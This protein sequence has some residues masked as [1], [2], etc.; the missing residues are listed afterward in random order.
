VI[1]IHPARRNAGS[2]PC[3]PA[4]DRWWLTALFIP[5][6]AVRHAGY[7]RVMPKVRR[8]KV[9]RW[10]LALVA[11]ALLA[12][13][14]RAAAAMP[15]PLA[16]L[17]A[18][19]TIRRST[20]QP[21]AK[22]VRY[23]ICST[24]VPS[25]DGTPLDV[26]VTL[27]V[28]SA[29]HPRP[30][31]V[32]LHGFL[33]DKTEYLSLSRGGVGADRGT[34]AYKTV[35]WN[36]VWFASRGYVVLNYTARGMGAS[37]GQ[38][39]LAS[40]YIEVRDT[41]YLT[42]LLIDDGASA[43]PLARIAARRI[44][45]IG[46]SYG[47]GQA[48]LLLTTKGAGAP[49]Y[50]SWLSP[51]GRLIEL[52]AIVPGFTW[53]DLLS[54]LV[55]NGHQLAEGVV[56]PATA[57]K[58]TGIG[59]Q[60]LI[61][62]FLATANTKLPSESIGWL[63]RFNAGEP[64][65]APSDPVIP[66]AE[67]AL[68][69]DRSA[70]FQ[71]AFFAALR[72]H[73]QRRVPV[74]A[75]QGWT[76]GIFPVLEVLRMVNRLQSVSPGYPIETYFGDFEHLVALDRVAD[77]RYWHILGNR[78]LDHYLLGHRRRPRFDARAALSNCDPRTFGP[79]FEANSF[80]KLHRFVR[81][82]DL[83]G[84]QTTVSPLAD[85]RGL[86]SDPVVLSEARGHGCITTKLPPTP[87]V[88]TYAIALSQPLTLFGLPR[89]ELRYTSTGGDLELDSRLWDEA[90]DGTQTLV[91][92]G[93]YRAI[94][95]LLTPTTVDYELFGNAWTF[96]AGHRIMLEVTQDDASYLRA[97]NFAS[98]TTIAGARLSLPVR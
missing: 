8:F 67:R 60:T 79:V 77:F 70:Y 40:K 49:Q 23:R 97:D 57:D 43:H 78:L 5:C 96:P 94:G 7:P 52:A 85:P 54:S 13:T 88:A 38:I 24:K 48:W 71:N 32:F 22:A 55:P 47:G 3:S 75:A 25:F 2:R 35:D 59:K 51:R 39:G 81:T 83:G 63:A 61:D 87:G 18:G 10:S 50:G 90:P 31:I 86:A 16:A 95:P 84:T 89:L 72:A 30:L 12:G 11:L 36:N 27:P 64:Y 68:T 4:V 9:G 91:T 92:R 53:T 62:G 74:L 46:S 17:K 37:G 42:G 29:R 58:P 93:A 56:D 15:D 80:D 69:V 76:D 66:V 1:D 6:A 45:V 14:G 98:T 82:F 20:D 41:Q 26:T 44:G 33:N 19:C 65:D 34:A 21:P 28:R 73:R